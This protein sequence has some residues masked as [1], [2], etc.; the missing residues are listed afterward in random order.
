MILSQCF[1]VHHSKHTFRGLG[2]LFLFYYFIKYYYN[3]NMSNN[4]NN[5]Q[6]ML[7]YE[8]W[9][10]VALERVAVAIGIVANVANVLF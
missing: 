6:N 5:A 3:N 2:L 4:F 1:S 9:C 8:C 7:L 10:F